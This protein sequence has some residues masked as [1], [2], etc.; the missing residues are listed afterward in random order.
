MQTEKLKHL[1]ELY[2][3]SSY[4]ECADKKISKI[5]HEFADKKLKDRGDSIIKNKKQ[6]IAIALNQADT[7]CKY[8]PSEKQSLISKVNENLNSSKELNLSNIIDTKKALEFLKAKSKYKQIYIF[9]KLLWDKIIQMH[10]DEINLDKNAWKEIAQ[11][12]KI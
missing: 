8:T 2:G 11:I 3:G 4:R 10:L 6:A 1:A 9:K 7:Q 12:Q 5:M